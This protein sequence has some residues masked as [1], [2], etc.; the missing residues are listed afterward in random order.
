MPP[1]RVLLWFKFTEMVLQMRPKA[2]CA[3]PFHP[4]RELR[5]AMRW[6]TKMGRRVWPYELR[7]FLFRDRRLKHGPTLAEFW[8]ASQEA[9]EELMT[10]ARPERRTSSEQL[11]GIKAA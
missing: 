3:H 2:L 6:Y 8:G 7:N 1:W 10:L 5:Q 4:D 11:R 9:E